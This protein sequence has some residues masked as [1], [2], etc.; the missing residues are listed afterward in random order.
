MC[1]I[2]IAK[3]RK[4]TDEEFT[5]CFNRNR[6]G[7]GMAWIEDG[8]VNYKKGMMDLNSA[9]TFYKSK[10]FPF[11]HVLHFRI[12]TSG[13]NIPE[14]THPFL[15]NKTSSL[16]LDYVGKENLLFHNGVISNWRDKLIKYLIISNANPLGEISDTRALAMI[17]SRTKSSYLEYE[18][19][20][21]FVVFNNKETKIWGGWEIENGALF[22]NR[23]YETYKQIVYS[24][25]SNSSRGWG[26]GRHR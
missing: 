15:I 14:L 3:S 1:V 22:S 18:K 10:D 2:A 11:P 9:L 21:R 24:G 12:G 20:D 25:A 8:F 13:G 7:F 23:A 17:L 5:N 16:K 19:Y 4:I 6:D 26:Y